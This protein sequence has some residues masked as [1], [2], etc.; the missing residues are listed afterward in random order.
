MILEQALHSTL[1]A[2]KHQEPAP[3]HHSMD[4]PPDLSRRPMHG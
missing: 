3:L 2:G 4:F 1:L